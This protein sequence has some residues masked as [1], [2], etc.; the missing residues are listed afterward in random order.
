MYDYR[1]DKIGLLAHI[2]EKVRQIIG[3]GAMSVGGWSG[4][5]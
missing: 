5:K 2:S 4:V 3:A 1:G